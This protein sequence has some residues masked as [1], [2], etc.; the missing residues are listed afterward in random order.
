MPGKNDTVLIVCEN[1][2]YILLKRGDVFAIHSG[3][4]SELAKISDRVVYNWRAR[5]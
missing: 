4:R 1:V 3:T 2:L 5:P